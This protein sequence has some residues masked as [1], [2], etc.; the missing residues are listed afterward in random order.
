MKKSEFD[1]IHE[2]AFVGGG[3]I[4]NNEVSQELA[5]QSTRGEI[6]HFKEVTARDLRFHKCY[7]AL[8][9]QIYDYL[10]VKFKM[11][12]PESR[13]YHFIKHLKGDYDVIFTFKDGTRMVEYESIAFGNMS[14]KRFEEYIREQLPFIYENVIGVYFK[15]DMYDGIIQTIEEDFKKFLSKL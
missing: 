14:Q 10:P 9:R 5:D 8:L 2:L 12:V 11:K 1:K 13:F 15:G 4:P 6:F 3:W 7:F